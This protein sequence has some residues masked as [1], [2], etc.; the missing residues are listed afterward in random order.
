MINDL[1]NCGGLAPTLCDFNGSFTVFFK[2]DD[3][4]YFK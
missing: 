1:N 3:L 2:D 4:K